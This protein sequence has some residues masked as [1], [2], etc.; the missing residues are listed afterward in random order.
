VFINMGTPETIKE[1]AG[2][3][4]EGAIEAGRDPNSSRS[5]PRCA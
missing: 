3:V 4:R 5:L 1:I 2:R